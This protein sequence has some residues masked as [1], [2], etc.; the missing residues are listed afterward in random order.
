MTA[1][2]SG[3]PGQTKG[4]QGLAL[5][6]HQRLLEGDALVARQHRFA[7]TDEAVAVAHRRRHVGDL[8]AA[9]LALLGVPPS[10]LKASWKK[11]SM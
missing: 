8:E 4:G 6:R 5:R 9:R 7:N 1:S 3:W 11:D 2:S 10:R